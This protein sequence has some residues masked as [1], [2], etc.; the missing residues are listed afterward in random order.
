[1]LWSRGLIPEGRGRLW[2]AAAGMLV[3]AVA[4]TQTEPTT[5]LLYWGG[6]TTVA[7][8]AAAIILAALEESGGVARSLAWRPLRAVGLASYS[9]YLW[10][11]P[12]FIWAV[13]VVPD[14]G[15]DRIALALSV[16]ALLSTA[17][18]V[19]VE[20]PVMQRR[21]RIGGRSARATAE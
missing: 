12:V 11:L 9:V 20:R 17:S 19:L 1:M 3:L 2:A 7:L 5:P 18:Y 13:R 21:G 14:P 15:V 6:Y 4:L 8:A 16:T 10:H